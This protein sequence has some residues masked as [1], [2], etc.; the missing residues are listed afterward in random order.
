MRYIFSAIGWTFFNGVSVVTGASSG[1][2]EKLTTSVQ[3]L[4]FMKSI[5]LEIETGAVN[6]GLQ[7]PGI[8]FTVFAPFVE[9]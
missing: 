9:N 7:K 1:V 8:S 2:S 5:S 3:V 4:D 6:Q